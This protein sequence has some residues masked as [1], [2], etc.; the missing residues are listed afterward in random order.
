IRDIERT[1]SRL[2]LGTGNPRDL[3]SLCSSLETI[4]TLKQLLQSFHH[5]STPH[6][7]TSQT[8]TPHTQP[9]LLSIQESL[10]PLPELT[11]HLRAALAE[12]PPLSI[13]DGG[14]IRQGFNPD[15]DELRNAAANGK[16]WLASL[17]EREIQRTGIKSLKV[18]Y[19]SV[20]G[21]FIEVTR[22]NLH[23]VP[24]DYIRKQTTVNGER[25]ITPEL[26]QIEDKI[27]GAEERARSLEAELFHQLRLKTLSYL[28]QIQ[29]SASAI[30]QL[31]AL[32]SLAETARL[33]SYCRPLV[34]TSKN[35]HIVEG[36]HPVLDARSDTERFVPNDTHLDGS[37]KRIA[38]ITGPNMAGK[39]TYIRQVALLVLMAQIGSFIPA[40]SAHIGIADRIF[41]RV[42]ASDDL[43]SGRSTFLVEMAETANI[44]NCATERSLV[45]LDEIGRGTSTFDGL[46]IA[47]SVA[48]FL[49]D[50]IRC[51]T[52][53][54][55]HYHE[56]TDLERTCNAVLNLNVAVREWEDK[57]LFLHKILPGR[58]DQ[59]YGIHVAKLAGL[60][61][62]VIQRAREILRNLERAEL[63][64][65]GKPAIAQGA[66]RR[67]AAI[68]GQLEFNLAPPLPHST[69][70]P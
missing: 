62:D 36:R 66:R 7:S 53:F 35:L 19:N 2:N 13:H 28:N 60:P 63:N 40:K 20:F 69:P 17:Q 64:A 38:I 8:S 42:G 39:S 25:F 29:Q 10:H 52:L 59:S 21:Y 61:N 27:L 45:I 55:T 68:L 65:D 15:L 12:P 57:I 22:A 46:S 34:D 67:A 6:T 50:Q 47:W 49:H 70:N 1:L 18:R 30:A 16:Q 26:K 9:L 3:F 56:L 41:T 24:P 31:D 33:H 44:L 4:P 23:A 11:S 32:A 51:R 58:A 48:E 54:A 14:I 43:A 37:N 5:T